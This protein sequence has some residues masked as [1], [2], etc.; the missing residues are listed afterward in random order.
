MK[1]MLGQPLVK[2]LENTPAT[3]ASSGFYEKKTGNEGVG[4][5]KV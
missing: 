2:A 3:F 5:R 1:S 4:L